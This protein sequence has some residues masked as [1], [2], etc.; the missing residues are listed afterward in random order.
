[1]FATIATTETTARIL[2]ILE[3]KILR[4]REH[5]LKEWYIADKRLQN[6]AKVHNIGTLMTF[7]PIFKT[8]NI[9]INTKDDITP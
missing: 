2:K 8:T 5:F 1:M 3:K 4:D 9:T 7:N 6:V